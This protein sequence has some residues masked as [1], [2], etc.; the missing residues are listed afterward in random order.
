MNNENENLDTIERAT[1]ASGVTLSKQ[2]ETLLDRY[3]AEV[4]SLAKGLRSLSVQDVAMDVREHVLSS[5]RGKPAPIAAPE[6]QAALQRVGSADQWLPLEELPPWR[7]AARRLLGSPQLPYVAF[8]LMVA[9]LML[10]LNFTAVLALASFCLARAAATRELPGNQWQRWLIYPPLIV[11]YSIALSVLLLWP[12]A[13]LVGRPQAE[14]GLPSWML[15]WIRLSSNQSIPVSAGVA[16][17]GIWV[18]ALGLVL[19]ARPAIVRASLYPFAERISRWGTILL[20]FAG[21]LTAVVGTIIL[22]G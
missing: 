6:M 13:A 8:A 21:V 4:R 12:S 19:T 3:L 20:A 2:A 7:S 16:A 18:A 1:P 9:G 14:V 10:P 22:R 5:L 11:V 15:H 17:V